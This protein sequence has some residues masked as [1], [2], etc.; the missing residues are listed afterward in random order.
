MVMAM[1]VCEGGEGRQ[2]RRQW[3]SE[4]VSVLGADVD[5]GGGYDDGEWDDE[6]WDVLD[7]E[8]LRLLFPEPPHRPRPSGRRGT[9][10]WRSEAGLEKRAPVLR[11]PVTQRHLALLDDGA[12]AEMYALMDD[13]ERSS[14]VEPD[15]EPAM[16][17]LQRKQGS[18]ELRQKRDEQ[19]RTPPR[20]HYHHHRRVVHECTGPGP[21]PRR[22]PPPPPPRRYRTG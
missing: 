21:P 6:W 4:P 12:E 14:D 19:Q 10:V 20:R 16:K 9:S 15:F 1:E 7:Q 17:P 11:P 3:E 13:K 22:P 8:L 18:R 5:E 2:Q